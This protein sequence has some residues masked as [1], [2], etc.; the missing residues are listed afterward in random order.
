MGTAKGSLGCFTLRLRARQPLNQSYIARARKRSVRSEEF[1][2]NRLKVLVKYWNDLCKKKS[3]SQEQREQI[4][5]EFLITT[6]GLGA[7]ARRDYK[8][9]ALTLYS[10]AKVRREILR[11]FK[12]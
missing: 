2:H 4:F 3:L 8:L 9:Q 1:K 11:E 7:T 6:W 12:K 5:E 10:S